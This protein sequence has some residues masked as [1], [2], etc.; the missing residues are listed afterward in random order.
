MLEERSCSDRRVY[1]ISCPVR[2]KRKWRGERKPAEQALQTVQGE[3]DFIHRVRLAHGSANTVGRPGRR[4]I[5]NSAA[6]TALRRIERPILACVRSVQC[7]QLLAP[8]TTIH[9]Q[10]A[11]PRKLVRRFCLQCRSGRLMVVVVSR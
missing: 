7:M 11:K 9:K 2:G 4:R 8:S 1:R 6:A 3:T 10:E 5:I